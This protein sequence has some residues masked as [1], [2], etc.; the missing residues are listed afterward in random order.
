MIA[1][2]ATPN[3]CEYS[4]YTFDTEV[5]DANT[6]SHNAFRGIKRHNV[7]QLPQTHEFQV[8]SSSVWF[9]LHVLVACPL[10]HF[11]TGSAYLFAF[12]CLRLQRPLGKEKGKG[13]SGANRCRGER[14]IPGLKQLLLYA[15]HLHTHRTHAYT[16]TCFCS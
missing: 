3:W 8:F 7:G 12:P 1:I 4:Y 15:I 10:R 9:T 5:E 2:I 14:V 16:H 13:Q 11:L 6:K